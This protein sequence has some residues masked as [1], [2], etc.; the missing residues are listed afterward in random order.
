MDA[1]RWQISTD[2][3]EW[4]LWNPAGDELF[5]RGPTGVLALAFE[6]DPTFTRGALTQLFVW[7]ILGGGES[8]RRMDIR[9]VSSHK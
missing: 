4:P 7:V 1:G 9:I 3:G 2:G 5:Y 6:A 8:A